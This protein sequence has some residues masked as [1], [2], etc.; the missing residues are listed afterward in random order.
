MAIMAERLMC[1]SSNGKSKDCTVIDAVLEKVLATIPLG[2]KPEFA[3]TDNQGKV[4]VNN[5]DTSDM[6]VIDSNCV[7][8]ETAGKFGT[9][10]VTTQRGSRTMAL[11]SKTHKIYLPAAEFAP[12][13]V[14]KAEVPEPRPTMVKGSVSVFVVGK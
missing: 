12:A 13:S 9:E 11:D 6:I 7:V 5:E 14:P 10:T 3:T 2:G 1:L 8:H 4:F